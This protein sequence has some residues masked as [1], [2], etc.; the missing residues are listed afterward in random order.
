MQANITSA[1]KKPAQ[2]GTFYD[3]MGKLNVYWESYKHSGD[4]A[5]N[6]AN[7]I[8]QQVTDSYINAHEMMT[9]LKYFNTQEF[10]RLSYPQ[11]RYY[12]PIPNQWTEMPFKVQPY[13]YD[14]IKKPIRIR[15][16]DK[17]AQHCEQLGSEKA[18]SSSV[19]CI[20]KHNTMML[21]IATF[22]ALYVATLKL[23][24]TAPA[25]PI[26]L[27]INAPQLEGHI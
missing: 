8:G 5:R 11:W 4:S 21:A 20:S 23:H 9:L 22:Y 12:S 27:H 26:Y 1:Y 7:F 18:I 17:R 16:G 14:G 2:L 6:K 13:G 24:S 15:I 25:V 3:I 19:K 10:C